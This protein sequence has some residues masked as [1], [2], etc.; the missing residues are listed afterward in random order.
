MLIDYSQRPA[1]VVW[2]LTRACRLR[3]VHCRAESRPLRDPNELTT[4]EGRAMLDQIALA[5]PAL[6][7]LTGG[8]P[9]RRED[10][11]VLIEHATGNG[12]RVAFSPSATPDFLALDFR[13]LK[14]AGVQRVSVSLDGATK[15]S[16]NS[17][18][19]V[20]RAWDWT[21][22]AIGKLREVGL[23]FQI[24]TTITR[25]NIEEFD[26]MCLKV[27]RLEPAGWTIFLVVP[28][29]R[30]GLDELPGGEEVEEL[31]KKLLR[32]SRE[33]EFEIRTTEGQH[34][35]RVVAQNLDGGRPLPVP[36]P[37]ND[38]KG[39]AFISH[40]GEICPSGFLPLV[41][42]NVRI[43]GFLE[44]YQNSE[45]FRALRDPGKLKGRCGRCE[46]RKICGGS[47]ARAYGHSGD[48]LA[49]D[50]L[51]CFEA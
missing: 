7:I 41:A 12:L 44:T 47:R 20:S 36:P 8:D 1:V 25:R 6:L 21:S 38:G 11:M 23:P 29:G 13:A 18:R 9:S 48:M 49:E 51:C 26:A 42:G 16:H 15:E 31:F 45:I 39:F 28:T 34:Y 14:E 24:N 27:K 50:P 10:L 17:F 46:Y 30:A 37:V 2:E 3:C 32:F 35:R 22:E 43:D 5:N 19:G 33:V 40:V 4:D